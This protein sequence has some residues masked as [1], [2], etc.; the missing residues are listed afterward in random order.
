MVISTSL[1]LAPGTEART[2]IAS[3][4]AHTSNGRYRRDCPSPHMGT[5]RTTDSSNNRSIAWRRV[6]NSLKGSQREMLMCPPCLLGFDLDALGLYLLALGKLERQYSI[7]KRRLGFVSLET[8][9]Q[10]DGARKTAKVPL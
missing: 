5:G 10:L 9:G 6:I 8:G 2:T 7:L 4:V 1:G 3:S